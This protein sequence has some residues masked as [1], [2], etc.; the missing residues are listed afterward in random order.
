MRLLMDAN[1][2]P[3]HDAVE[4]HSEGAAQ[5]FLPHKPTRLREAILNLP[6]HWPILERCL[7]VLSSMIPPAA[8]VA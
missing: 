5:G 7:Y 3:S 4:T 1:I 2:A 8:A 6:G